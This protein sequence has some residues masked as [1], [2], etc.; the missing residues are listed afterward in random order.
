[1]EATA[2]SVGKSVLNGALSYAKSAV[3]EEL[4]LQ[5]GVGRDQAFI[6]GELEMMQSFLMSAHDEGDGNN[7]V[8]KTWVKQVRDVAYI[9]EDCLQ[10]FA[11]RVNRQPWWR[12]LIHRHNV[13]N[14]MK[15]LRAKVDDVSQRNIRY[16]LIKGSS[17]AS[18][19][20]SN[21]KRPAAG[22]S[23]STLMFGI[24]GASKQHNQSNVDLTQLLMVSCNNDDLGLGVIAVWGTSADLG[25]MSIIRAVYEN[26]DVTTKFTC[27]AWVRLTH[28]FNP[29]DFIQSLVEQFHH[30]TTAAVMLEMDQKTPQQLAQEFNGYVNK[31][32][33]LIVINDLSTIE[34]WDRVKRCFPNNNMGCRIIVS[35]PQAEVATLCAGQE[36]NVSKLKQLSAHQYIYAFHNMRSEHE[37]LDLIGTSSCSN[38]DIMNNTDNSTVPNSEIIEDTSTEAADGKSLTWNRKMESHIVGRAQEKK[39]II[40]LISHPTRESFEVISIWGMG[41][42]GKTTIVKDIYQ[43]QELIG[44]FEKRA[45]ATILRPFSLLELLRSLFMQLDTETSEKKADVGLPAS[46]TERLTSSK[47]ALAP[48]SKKERLPSVKERLLSMTVDD[49]INEL[50]ILVDKKRCL[51]VLDDVSSTAE[52]DRLQPV[53]FQKMGNTSRIIVTTRLKSIALHCSEKKQENIYKLEDLAYEYARELFTKKVFRKIIDLDKH[54]PELV[55]PAELILRKCGRLPLAIVTVGGFLA[56]Q[57]KTSLEWR[58]FYD[59]ISA[60]MEMNPELTTIRSVLMKSYDGLPFHLKSCF[61]YTSIFSEDRKLERR[62]LVLRWTAEG[63]SREVRDKSAEEI[64]DSYFLELISRSM[65]L[66]SQKSF[67]SIKGIDS[68]QV[69][70]LIREISIS[71]SME[72][73]LVLR[74]EK[75]CKLNS[76]QGNARHLAING[77]WE[78][79]QSDFERMVD[80]PRVRSVTV[81]GKWRPFFMSVKMRMLRVLDLEDTT[82]LV[83]HHI[84]HIGKLLHLIYLSLRGCEDIYHLPDSIGNLMQLQTLDIRGTSILILPRSIV[85]LRKLQYLRCSNNN[86]LKWRVGPIDYYDSHPYLKTCMVFCTGC[87]IPREVIQTDGFNQRDVCTFTCCAAI[88]FLMKGYGNG[89]GVRVPRGIRRMKALHTLQGVDLV[90]SRGIA[91]LRNI[92]GLMGLR[93]LGVVRLQARNAS[94]FCAVVSSLNLL[95]SLSVTPEGGHDLRLDGISSPPSNLRNLKLNMATFPIQ[96]MAKLPEWVKKLENLVKLRIE[97]A[98][99]GQEEQ[100]A[101]IGALGNLLN[102]AVLRLNVVSFRGEELHFVAEAFRSLVVLELSRTTK[103]RLVE[104]EQGAMP[105]LQ[106][107]LLQYLNTETRFLGLDSLGSIKEVGI[108]EHLITE[109]LRAQVALNRNKPILNTV[110]PG[111]FE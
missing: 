76:Q 91:F 80:M 36:Y 29:K 71:K 72:E 35:T 108:T 94:E 86:K 73:N 26:P 48:A 75:G 47:Q 40:E 17:A 66:P 53:I 2:L 41:G 70:D 54:Y 85:K 21:S 24:H 111:R 51:I 33:Y 103:M 79:E 39:D 10:D 22:K 49:L 28:P 16:Q 23:G 27:R 102:L 60:E 55:E 89:V 81:L 31:K 93:K 20:S 63:Y 87:C 4:A 59:H 14:Q 18:T 32:R 64:S 57:P 8:V 99:S 83:D 1:M 65:I 25:Q 45:C 107:L 68:C 3:A 50:A 96:S 42:L 15:E 37:T 58:K 43:S 11:V 44:T 62:R 38:E 101:A 84:K 6:T 77:N 61:L 110:P 100:D 74:L 92:K 109:E 69:H 7:M 30:T 97:F 90:A 19:S 12:T 95:E 105:K 104:F 82:G 52:W 9:V 46:K 78:G 67:H 13:A 88:P 98:T 5:L 56:N 106:Q 34:E